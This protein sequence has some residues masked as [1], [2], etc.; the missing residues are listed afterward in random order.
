MSI[1]C[2]STSSFPLSSDSRCNPAE[3]VN[4]KNTFTNLTSTNVQDAIVE[5]SQGATPIAGTGSVVLTNSITPP[6]FRTV[7]VSVLGNFLAVC[8]TGNGANTHRI[9]IYDITNP[10]EPVFLSSSITPNPFT[11]YRID[12]RGKYIFIGMNGN[13]VIYD[14]TNFSNLNL[15]VNDP[16]GSQAFDLSNSGCILYVAATAGQLRA[17][18]ISTITNPVLISSISRP[19]SGLNVNRTLI[20]ASDFG[21]NEAYIVDVSDPSNMIELGSV[22]IGTGIPLDTFLYGSTGY[23]S[24]QDGLNS[25]IVILDISNTSNPI[26]F[27]TVNLNETIDF[28]VDLFVVGLVSNIVLYIGTSSGNFRSFNVT[29]PSNPIEISNISVGNNSS[30]RQ[31][32]LYGNT[33]YAAFRGNSNADRRVYIFT[34]ENGTNLFSEN[35]NSIACDN[36]T[37]RQDCKIGNSLDISGGISTGGTLFAQSGICAPTIN[38]FS[39]NTLIPIIASVPP[40]TPPTSIGQLYIDTS[41][42]GAYIST[43]IVAVA[44]WVIIT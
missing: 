30:F 43:G 31:L 11:S 9:S 26:V 44:D 6:G 8:D 18:D 10:N 3:N 20:L 25:R 34:I 12:F 41:L 28:N 4:F 36:I 39:V 33:I 14:A 37:I 32:A 29:D 40:S 19:T 23:V 27:G 16:I 2:V 35:V 17:Y 21:S 5:V 7:G 15:I 13:I 38:N 1:Q 42:P 24:V 22:S